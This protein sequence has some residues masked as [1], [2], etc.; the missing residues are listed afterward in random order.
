MCGIF[1]DSIIKNLLLILTVK[2]FENLSVYDEVI[3]RT[4]MCQFLGDTLYMLC[5][6]RNLIHDDSCYC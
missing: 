2:K 1:N 6:H 5:S 4:K 3:K